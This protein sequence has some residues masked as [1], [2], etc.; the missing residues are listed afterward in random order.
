[1]VMLCIYEEA[2]SNVTSTQS[3]KEHGPTTRDF[4]HKPS[5]HFIN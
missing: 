2:A 3:F 5:T 4:N 1:M